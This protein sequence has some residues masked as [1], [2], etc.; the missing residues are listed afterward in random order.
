MVISVKPDLLE[1]L[2]MSIELLE[3]TTRLCTFTPDV[4]TNP[5]GV[6]LLKTA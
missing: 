2:R 1:R 4:G 3:N 5:P 6:V